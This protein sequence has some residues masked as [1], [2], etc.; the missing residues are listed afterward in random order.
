[1]GSQKKKNCWAGRSYSGGIFVPL[2]V[3]CNLIYLA[4]LLYALHYSPY[5]NTILYT[6]TL[7][8]LLSMPHTKMQCNDQ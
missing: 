2:Y 5:A 8:T 6:Y 4:Y 3:L 7:A 1:M